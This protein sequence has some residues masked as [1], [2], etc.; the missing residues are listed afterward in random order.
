MILK[1][2]LFTFLNNTS[3]FNEIF[4][5]DVTYDNVKSHKKT[6]A[7]PSLWKMHFSKTT[8]G[9]SNLSP[10]VFRVKAINYFCKKLHL[11]CFLLGFEYSSDNKQLEI[12][13]DTFWNKIC[14]SRNNWVILKGLIWVETE[15]GKNIYVLDN[16]SWRANSRQE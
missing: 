14:N 9:G 12:F 4:R 2:K 7:S 1:K 15:K 3:N 6:S 13:I 11:I 16:I 5:K 8:N 10:I